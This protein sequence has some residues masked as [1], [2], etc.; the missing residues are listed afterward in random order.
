[1]FE[2]LSLGGFEPPIPSSSPPVPPPGSQR[3]VPRELLFFAVYLGRIA[4]AQS[5]QLAHE[6]INTQP[7]QTK[8]HRVLHCTLLP[9][10]DFTTTP[11][12]IVQSLLLAGGRVT[13][14][15]FKM[16]WD[17]VMRFGRGGAIGPLV[18]RAGTGETELMALQRA[19][20]SAVEIVLPGFKAKW[21]FTPHVT[22]ARTG[23]VQD[24]AI[25][26]I[27]LTVR[28]FSLVHS[29]QNRGWHEMLGSWRLQD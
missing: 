7:I 27:R 23:F 8:P 9:F 12:A 4:A 11:E 25:E 13:A 14:P 1:M 5:T 10:D 29:I 22:L 2:Q 20:C 3:F 26:P 19:I 6:L 28:E 21:S 15:S 24:R 18:L 17:H 16:A